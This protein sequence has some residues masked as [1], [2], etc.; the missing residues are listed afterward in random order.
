MFLVGVEVRVLI[1]SKEGVEVD[2]GVKNDVWGEVL[3]EG[4]REDF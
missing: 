1:F 2:V 3:D 4:N